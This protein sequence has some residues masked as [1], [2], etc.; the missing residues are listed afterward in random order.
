MLRRES[1][2]AILVRSPFQEPATS[3][4]DPR[5]RLR[6]LRMRRTEFSCAGAGGIVC[7]HDQDHLPF[8]ALIFST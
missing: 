6:V 7:H 2:A 8:A 5:A 4:V 3:L 1:D